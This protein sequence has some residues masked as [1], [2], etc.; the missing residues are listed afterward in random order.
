M[1][2]NTPILSLPYPVDADT[3]DVPRDLQALALAIDA[4][5][6]FEAPESGKQDIATAET[7][8]SA[9]Y[10]L[11][12]TPDRVQ[13]ITLPEDGLL[14]VGYDALFKSSDAFAGRAAIF[15]GANQLRTRT[16]GGTA[17]PITQA[18]AT[19]GTAD[20]YG[21]L[22]SCP[23]GLAGFAA[24]TNDQPAPL[25]TGMTV[26]GWVRGLVASE[27]AVEL[28][29]TLFGKTV[30]GDLATFGGEC[31]IFAAAGTYDVSVQ[32]KA[33]TGSVTVKDR[34]LWVRALVF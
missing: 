30:A 15:I 14:A 18:A 3:V 2:S 26:G 4:L 29:G 1:P 34:R 20:K 22:A 19:S 28:A 32:F 21:H 8:A 23:G 27:V 25:S 24:V 12:T 13:S 16:P 11:L 10:G 6:A 5:E 17:V 33:T 7:R 9:T 31:L